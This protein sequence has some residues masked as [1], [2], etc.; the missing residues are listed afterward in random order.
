MAELGPNYTR[1]SKDHVKALREV[2]NE[3]RKRADLMEEEAYGRK[4]RKRK[5]RKG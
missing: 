4:G 3:L 5:G 1:G 2:A